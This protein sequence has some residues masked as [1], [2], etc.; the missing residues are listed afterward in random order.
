MPE[1]FKSIADLQVVID[2]NTE[3]LA[4]GLT[5]AHGLVQKFAGEG[6]KALGL[7]DQASGALTS[8]LAG[9]QSRL[10]LVGLALSQVGN[11]LESAR[12][13]LS[14]IAKETGTEENFAKVESS[15][16]K[17]QKTLIGTV[18]SALSATSTELVGT[19]SKLTG[20]AEASENATTAAHLLAAVAQDRLA[21]SI[22]EVNFRIESMAPLAK[23]SLG[24]LEESLKRAQAQVV[25]LREAAKDGDKSETFLNSDGFAQQVDRNAAALSR[26]ADQLERLLPVTEMFIGLEKIG[27]DAAKEREDQA[28]HEADLETAGKALETLDKQ[29]VALERKAAT[30][31]MSASAIAAYNAQS[32]A[33]AELEKAEVDGNPAAVELLNVKMAKFREL[34]GTID[35]FSEALKR[36]QDVERQDKQAARTIENMDGEVR[37][38]ERRTN[39]LTEGAAEAARLAAIEKATAEIRRSGRDP[40]EDEAARIS[41][42]ADAAY[43]AVLKYEDMKAKLAEVRDVGLVVTRSLDNAFAT[44]ART[45]EFNVKKMVA[46]MLQDLAMLSFKQGVTGPLLQFLTGGGTEGGKGLLGE[47]FGGFRAEGGPVDPSQAYIVGERGPELFMPSA[48][49]NVVPNH[50]L[51]GG[52]V[53]I[54]MPLTIDARGAY[55]ESISEIKQSVATL[56]ASIPGR[57]LEA[58]REASQRGL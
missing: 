19:V 2:A 50:A 45:G 13:G 34:N 20:F 29:I 17:L 12:A 22:D 14:Q 55:P 48:A 6:S 33:M 30:L 46:A 37:Q 49:G 15:A 39:A 51:G 4:G 11:V 27:I 23:Q 25:A 8:G 31:G 36:K 26:Q 57:A 3:K 40:N 41:A 42:N 47:L 21:A 53:T 58:V 56:H 16:D 7:F 1:G 9:M 38:I 18:S 24:T 10:G 32:A 43:D 28:K 5:V 35:A 54:H 44:F 52:A